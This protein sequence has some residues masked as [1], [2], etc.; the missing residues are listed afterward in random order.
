MIS[1]PLKGFP[2]KRLRKER[3]EEPNLWKRYALK[4]RDWFQY[5][6]WDIQSLIHR[7]Q[8]RIGRSYAYAKFG[9]LNHDFDSAFAYQ[10]LHFKFLR[11]L[12]CLLH[13]HAVQQKPV[14]DALREAIKITK[15]LGYNEYDEKYFRIHRKK[16]G[17]LKHKFIPII[18]ADGKHRSSTWKTWRTKCKTPAQKKQE[19][20]ELLAIEPK[21]DLDRR[22]DIDRLAE[23][24]KTY[25][26]HW[27]D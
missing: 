7:Y 12:D 4:V 26:R 24:L 5:R 2:Y 15:R 21:A 25:E 16:W 6:Y 14:M 10:L 8:E 9:W 11:I 1:K 22:A 3:D 20:K 18:D 17:E 13:G 27:W 19:T 23:L